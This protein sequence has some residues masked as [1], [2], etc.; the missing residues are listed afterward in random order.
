MTVYTFYPQVAGGGSSTF[1]A[2]D[3]AT[4]ELA[5]KQGEAVLAEHE[6]ASEVAIWRGETFLGRVGR[7]V[8]VV[9]NHAPSGLVNS[10]NP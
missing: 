8:S 10:A 6:S 9:D 7:D 5:L 3:L 2:Y 4:D 1:C